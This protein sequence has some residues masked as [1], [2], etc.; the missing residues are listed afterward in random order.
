[1]K[2]MEERILEQMSKINDTQKISFVA[3]SESGVIDEKTA[4][5]HID[6]Y[7]EWEPGKEYKVNQMRQYEGILYKCRQDHTA[8]AEHTP[9][10]VPALWSAIG[11]ESGSI[12]NPIPAVVNMEYIKGLYYVENGVVY[13]MNRA[14]M[15][16]GDS[17]PLAYTPSQLV[18]QYF[19]VITTK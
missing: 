18:G 15:A 7:D 14:G 11:V 10:I 3:L 1:M 2:T 6:L 16:D 19:E 9:S 17:I 5:D 4:S 8:Q 12:D 13:L